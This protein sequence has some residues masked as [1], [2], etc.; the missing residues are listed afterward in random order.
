MPWNSAVLSKWL[1]VRAYCGIWF[2][3]SQI[4]DSV[5]LL[6]HAVQPTAHSAPYAIIGHVFC[7]EFD[8]SPLLV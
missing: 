1:G 6:Q 5:E 2:N 7:E 8:Y 4:T 3:F